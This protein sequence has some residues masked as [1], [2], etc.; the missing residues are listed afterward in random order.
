MIKLSGKSVKPGDVFYIPALNPSQEQGF[1]MA[2]FIENVPVNVGYLLEVFARFYTIPPA[3][4]ED[5]DMSQRLF[6]PVMTS[7][8]FSEVPKWRVLFSDPY[9]DKSQSNYDDIT[10]SFVPYLWV[11]GKEIPKSQC[12]RDLSG[13][14]RPI[15]WR[16]LHLILRVNAHLAGIFNADEP[17]DYHRLPENMKADNPEAL[18]RAIALAEA[19]DDKFKLWA[20]QA[21]KKS[22]IDGGGGGSGI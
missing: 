13:I 16:A 5:I 22:R 9:Y 14:E 4:M 6:R 20:V 10:F 8:S 3:C 21:K 2:R 7:F 12:D 11:G 1:V 18:V 17:H 19:M 15:C